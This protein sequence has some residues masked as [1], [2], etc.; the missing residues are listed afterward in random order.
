[1][2]ELI[3]IIQKWLKEDKLSFLVKT[4][5]NINTSISQIT[6]SIT[7]YLNSEQGEKQIKRLSELRQFCE[8]HSKFCDKQSLLV[9]L[10]KSIFRY[11]I[12]SQNHGNILGDQDLESPRVKTSILKPIFCLAYFTMTYVTL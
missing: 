11:T 3:Q 4:L 1:M 10:R 9:D 5:E 7:K 6:H 2:G 12:T 8:L